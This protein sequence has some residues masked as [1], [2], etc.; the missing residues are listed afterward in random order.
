[1]WTFLLYNLF[2]KG[3]YLILRMFRYFCADYLFIYLY[4]I[5]FWISCNNLCSQ[6]DLPF[7]K[8]KSVVC[9]CAA[10]CEIFTY[11]LS[12]ATNFFVYLPNTV[13]QCTKL[14]HITSHMLWRITHTPGFVV[15]FV[16]ITTEVSIN[17]KTGAGQFCV[18]VC[19]Y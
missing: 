8:T 17:T 12:N 3:M 4:I 7:I 9:P 14:W 18:C 15:C 13:I 11:I 10:K 5:Y 6:Y 1:M 19:V 16:S 2:P